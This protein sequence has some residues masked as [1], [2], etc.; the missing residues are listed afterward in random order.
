MMEG[1]VDALLESW[2]VWEMLTLRCVDQ[3]VHVLERSFKHHGLIA[4]LKGSKAS[5]TRDTALESEEAKGR[6]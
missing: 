1:N 2:R 6:E 4:K 5:S 3:R